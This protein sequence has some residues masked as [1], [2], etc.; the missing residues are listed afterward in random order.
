MEVLDRSGLSPRGHSGKD[1]HADPGDLSARRALPDQDRRPVRGGDRR[2]A[3]GRPP[4]AAPVPAPR[5]VRPVHLLP[6]L[7]A[8]G[9]VHHRQPAE[10]AGDPAARA[11]RHRRRLHH[12]G[13]RADAGP[14]ALHRAYRPG[15]PARRG[16][17]QRS[18]PSCSPTRPGCGTTTSP[19]CSSASWARSR[20]KDLFTRYAAAY[21]DSYKDGHTPYE[22]MQ[23][24]AKLELLEEPGQLEMHLYRKRRPGQDGDAGARRPR[25]A[26]QGLPVRRADDALR[27]AAGAALAG[28]A[29]GR[30]AAVRDP[31]HRRH[32]LPVRLRPAAAGRA[33]RARR[34]ASAGGERVRGRLAGRGGGR[35]LQRAGAARRAHLASG[36]G[37]PGVRE[38]SAPGRHRLLPALHG[39]DLHRLSGDRPPAGASSSRPGSRRGCRSARRSAPGWPT[40]WPSGSPSCSTA[41]TASTRTGSCAP[42]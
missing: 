14:G 25:R 10:H 26:V 27:R 28:R 23:D 41:W 3:D 18:W 13:D 33:P 42:T 16:R 32:H 29:G 6:D 15:R 9:P 38:I 7:P 11:E 36:G 5:R 39:V 2:P 21:P 37:A 8:P 35:R 19:W 20:R 34:G 31:P 24:L 22:G 1:L 17:P 30:R 12:P 4:A 40:S